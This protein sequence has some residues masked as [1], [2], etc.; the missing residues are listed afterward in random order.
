GV[1]PPNGSPSLYPILIC[2][3]IIYSCA[4]ALLMISA[5]SALADVA[6][7][8]ELDTGKRQEGVFYSSRIL[9]GKLTSGFGHIVAGVAMD[10]IAFPDNAKP[11]EVAADVVHRL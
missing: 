4:G 2:F 9:F 1:M 11:G 3:F 7:E 5:L 8:Y 10:L 6:D